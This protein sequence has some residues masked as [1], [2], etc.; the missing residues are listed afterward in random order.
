MKK[1][2]LSIVMLTI[3]NS[4]IIYAQTGNVGINTPMPANTLTV[5]GNTSIG[6]AYINTPAPANGAIIEGNVGIGTASPTAKL[7]ISGNIR[8]ADGTQGD[9]KI[10]TSDANGIA[11]WQPA[12][13]STISG[14]NNLSQ[15]FTFITLPTAEFIPDTPLTLNKGVYTLYYY[16]Q[17]DYYK[18]GSTTDY[19]VLDPADLA[20]TFPRWIYFDFI[21][22]SGF[23]E[24]PSYGGSN[25]GPHVIP[26]ISTFQVAAKVS[27]VA[28]VHQDNTVIRPRFHGFAAYGRISN[29]GPILAV[30]M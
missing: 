24:F 6:T 1:I 30:K 20:G 27:Q 28:I 3:I 10:L 8:I 19:R 9:G 5:N 11:S 17:F 21:T 14:A 7:D 18:A 13:G 22:S 29:L 23:A 26:I 15:D 25:Y 2:L 16:V 12:P 4:N